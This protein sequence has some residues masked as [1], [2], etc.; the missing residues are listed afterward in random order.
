MNP[1]E[2]LK[3][4]CFAGQILLESGAETY[5]VEE[6]M[7]RIA[8]SFKVEDPHSFVMT[9]GI[10]F[11]CGYEG[12]TYTQVLRIRRRSVDLQKIELINDL[13]RSLEKQS[14]LAVLNARLKTIA[15][16][17]RH[18]DAK[19]I[20]FS[21]ISAF[22]FAM[23]FKASPLEWL[24]AFVLGM[25]LRYVMLQLNKWKI[26]SFLINSI[27]ASLVSVITLTIQA[28]G[29]LPSYDLVIISTIMLL[30]PGL[31]IT[32]AIRDYVAG[33]LVSGLARFTEA[34]L[35]ALSIAFGTGL[36]FS[37]WSLF[38]GGILG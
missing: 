11:S 36:V 15:A 24:Y 22:G 25:G 21:G 20:L 19:V 12:Q 14:D 26:N 37:L 7:E 9:T 2:L 3:T 29:W 13:S 31:A 35:I 5:R 16:L 30:V 23:F 28:I 6:T 27:G 34:F 32:N 1:N 8:K 33:D 4:I 18:S 38:V 17:K 10:M